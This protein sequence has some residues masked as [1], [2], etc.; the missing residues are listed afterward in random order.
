[1]SVETMSLEKQLTVEKAQLRTSLES[2]GHRASEAVDWRHHVR[3]RPVETLGAAMV[4]GAVVGALTARSR[5]QSTKIRPMRGHEGIGEPRGQLAPEWHRLKAGL[6][7]MVTDRA[8][9]A[10]QEFID[11]ATR[12]REA[13]SRPTSPMNYATPRDMQGS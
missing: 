13:S 4:L 12:P 1:M 5:A 9:V 11:H 10:A 3:T 2:I 7:G 6:I 8:M